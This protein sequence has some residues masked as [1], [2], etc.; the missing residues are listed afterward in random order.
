M[1][2]SNLAIAL[3][4]AAALPFAAQAQEAPSNTWVEGSYVNAE[5]AQMS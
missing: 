2:R 3:S 1:K 4:L 5:I